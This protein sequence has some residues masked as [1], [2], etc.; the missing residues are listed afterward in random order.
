MEGPTPCPLRV[1]EQEGPGDTLPAQ[2]GK[3]NE[4]QWALVIHG[5]WRGVGRWAVVFLWNVARLE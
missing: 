4:T 3:R 2:A 1:K 5:K